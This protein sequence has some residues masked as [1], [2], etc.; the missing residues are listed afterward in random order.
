MQLRLLGVL[1]DQENAC[2]DLGVKRL[3][4]VTR[5][6]ERLD[7]ILKRCEIVKV[8]ISE[9]EVARIQLLVIVLVSYFPE[10]AS[11][12]L[13]VFE[14]CL[15]VN[16]KSLDQTLLVNELIVPLVLSLCLH[17]PFFFGSVHEAGVHLFVH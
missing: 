7:W 4:T 9:H 12:F 17:V 1:A 16:L 8:L 3:V 11:C 5:T 15:G 14:L 6:E 13:D 10:L 2:V